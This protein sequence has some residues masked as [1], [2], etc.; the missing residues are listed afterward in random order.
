MAV[1]P[2]SSRPARKE[3]K[4]ELELEQAFGVLDQY[5]KS[6]LL[7][8]AAL[9]LFNEVFQHKGQSIVSFKCGKVSV[10]YADP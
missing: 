4:L 1:G 3:K 9:H 7:I 8:Y 5:L 10:V 2:L 6:P